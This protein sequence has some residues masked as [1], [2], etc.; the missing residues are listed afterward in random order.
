MV[1]PKGPGD[2]HRPHLGVAAARREVH[3]LLYRQGSPSLGAPVR[4]CSR[5]RGVRVIAVSMRREGQIVK[6]CLIKPALLRELRL[7]C[8]KYL[9]I[10]VQISE[11]Q[12][13]Y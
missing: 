8:Y 2:A 10:S 6:I 12:T 11:T 4:P 1:V 9:P 3:R 7:R 5:R 13:G